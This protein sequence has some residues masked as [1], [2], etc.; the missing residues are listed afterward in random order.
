MTER[1]FMRYDDRGR[2]VDRIVAESLEW[3]HANL[4]PNWCE[5]TEFV[6]RHGDPFFDHETQTLYDAKDP[7]AFNT[8]PRRAQITTL[9]SIHNEAKDGKQLTTKHSS[10]DYILEFPF[11]SRSEN[12]PI[13]L[14]LFF[15][16]M[17]T[18]RDIQRHEIILD[19]APIAVITMTEIKP[20]S[21]TGLATSMTHPHCVGHNLHE[22]LCATWEWAWA[23]Q[24][25]GNTE[26][27]ACLA[28]AVMT[29]LQ[30]PTSIVAEFSE[31]PPMAIRRFLY[32][33]TN[34]TIPHEWD[35]MPS[36]AML[37]W[38]KDISI[39]F[40]TREADQPFRVVT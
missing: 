11:T 7:V 5:I 12:D 4:G 3:C 34:A 19:V 10:N 6:N 17:R 20:Q 22:V 32:G 26:P 38:L 39:R 24:H 13:S 33:D 29:A 37:N 27:I 40:A 36:L 21:L 28:N 35:S 9:W 25:L 15:D 16:T 18:K 14:E 2:N 23:F 30:P 8:V 31:M 1:I